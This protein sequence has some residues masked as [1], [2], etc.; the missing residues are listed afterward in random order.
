MAEV[1]Q[2]AHI[3]G[4]VVALQGGQRFGRQAQA[5]DV[6][7]VVQASSFNRLFPPSREAG[8]L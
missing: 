6:E 3:A 2:L 1:F 7:A 4:K 8:G 5:S